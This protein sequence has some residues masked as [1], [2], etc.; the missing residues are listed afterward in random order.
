MSEPVYEVIK[1]DISWEKKEPPNVSVDATGNTRTGGWTNCRLEARIYIAPP[2]DGIQELDFVGDPPE[3]PSTDAITEVT[4][5]P[6][7][8]ECPEWMIGVRVIAETNKLP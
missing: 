8:Q 7:K 4:A 1:V 5:E 6:Y 2:E 3:G